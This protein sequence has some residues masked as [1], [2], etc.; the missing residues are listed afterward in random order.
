M[1]KMASLLV[2]AALVAGGLSGCT[3]APAKET[4]GGAVS[5]EKT[6][7]QEKTAAEK[8]NGGGEKT[9]VSLTYWQH[10]SAARDEMMTALVKTF[11]EQNPD[12][13]VKL[14][15]IPE[16]DYSQK[17]IPALATD[18]A[19]D[20]FQIQS[21]MV[22]KLAQTGAIKPLAEEVMSADSITADFVPAAVDGLKYDG[23]YY[24][25]PTDLQT[26]VMLWNKKLVAEAGL[27]AEKGP[28]TWDEFFD[29][30]RKLTKTEGGKL[31]Q[32]G[33]G[34]KGYAP[35]VLSII[36]QY[37]GAF[38]DDAAGQYVFAD[39]P[40]VLEAIEAY[41]A[42]YKTD[43]VYNTEFV[44]NW[45]GF[46]QGLIGLMLGHPAMIGNLPQ[47][48]PDLDFGVG[49]IP[50]KGDSHATCVT[51]WGY[52][53][54]AKAPDEAATRFIQFLSSDDVERQWTEKTGELPARKALLED[55]GLK[56]DPKVAVA[57]ESLND[58]FVGALQT[59]AL[60]TIWTE[61]MDRILQTDEPIET[62]LKDAQS[63]MNDELKNPV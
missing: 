63:K 22:A 16:G 5:Q 60:N 14:E 58:S 52:V 49:L 56:S 61:A 6:T 46:R 10:S 62:I 1:K 4:S 15:F 2:A 43:K 27:D 33:W 38:Y 39:D 51:S 44:K 45:A 20:V 17:L 31:V 19:P 37:G 24:G 18:T 34:G 32:S 13:K 7:D 30:S 23:K 12:I 53:M 55:A 41:T 36:K 50:A 59:S 42:P 3:K 21:G 8:E 47:T 40:K 29:W 35:E 48:A 54:S 28:Q 26:I 11:E 25:M 57:I 9:P